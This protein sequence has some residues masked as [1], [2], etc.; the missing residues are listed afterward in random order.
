MEFLFKTVLLSFFLLDLS[1]GAQNISRTADE[2]SKSKRQAD[3]E[4]SNTIDVIYVGD[5]KFAEHN[6][7]GDVY[8]YNESSII[9]DDFI[10]DGQ[11]PGVYINVA[12]KGN[13]RSEYMENRIVVDFPIEDPSPIERRFD[14]ER[15]YID[16]PPSVKA[17]DVK[18][19]SI[20]CEIFGISFGDVEFP[21][22]EL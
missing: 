16:L 20:W 14:H 13:S 21:E 7:K 10:Y 18:W 6:V 15:L 9:I 2:Q 11:G 5:F 22:V 17:T 12:T 19:L 8:I 4:D 1:F 3:E